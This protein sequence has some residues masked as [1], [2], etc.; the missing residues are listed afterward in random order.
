MSL[1]P[2]KPSLYL[3]IYPPYLFIVY[4]NWPSW[5]GKTSCSGRMIL[6]SWI[7]PDHL[8]VSCSRRSWLI[9]GR[10]FT[11][12]GAI[13]STVLTLRIS[14]HP[15]ACRWLWHRSLL[16]RSFCSISSKCLH[17]TTAFFSTCYP[18][19]GTVLI[20]WLEII[21][22]HSDQGRPL[23]DHF[24]ILNQYKLINTGSS[25]SVVK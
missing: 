14:V 15:N 7:N 22:H 13:L 18:S 25:F 8:G 5:L 20:T 21:F 12:G 19:L 4:A 24:D 2:V 16:H 10:W 6:R 23:A 9:P 11:S 1:K 3:L 17:W